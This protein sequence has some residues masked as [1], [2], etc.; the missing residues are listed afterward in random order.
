MNS[1]LDDATSLGEAGNGQP[2]SPY[3][4]AALVVLCTAWEVY[5][6]DVIEESIKVITEAPAVAP[7]D[8]ADSLRT[9]IGN[10]I[11]KK[12]N[13][14]CLAGDEWRSYTREYVK[15]KLKSLNTPSV[16]NVDELLHTLLGI[17]RA[18]DEC[19]WQGM[20]SDR[21][22]SNLTDLIEYRGEVVHRGPTP[23]KLNAPGV[24]EWISYLRRLADQLDYLICRHIQ[25]CYGLQLG[26]LVD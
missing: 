2:D 23:G 12:D 10:M 6:E 24:R 20:G 15:N 25:G 14:W 9:G 22:T 1:L 3:V 8:L 21:L 13:P 16:E 4:R 26:N 18:L 17:D 19:T 5:I 11:R 7:S